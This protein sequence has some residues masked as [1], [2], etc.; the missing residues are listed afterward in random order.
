MPFNRFS[1]PNNHFIYL[2]LLLIFAYSATGNID[3]GI[4]NALKPCAV[5]KVMSGTKNLKDHLPHRYSS[6]RISVSRLIL[7]ECELGDMPAEECEMEPLPDGCRG[8][9]SGKAC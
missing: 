4:V 6:G 8:A 2:K 9:V 7:S 5:K 3:T 1:T